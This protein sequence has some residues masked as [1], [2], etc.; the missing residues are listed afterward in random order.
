MR[1]NANDISIRQPLAAL[2]RA[3]FMTLNARADVAE[4]PSAFPEPFL[5]Y[6][7]RSSRE[8]SLPDLDKEVKILIQTLSSILVLLLTREYLS[9]LLHTSASVVTAMC[10]AACLYVELLLFNNSRHR[11]MRHPTRHMELADARSARCRRKTF[12]LYRITFRQN[13]WFP[14]DRVVTDECIWLNRTIRK[15]GCATSQ[16]KCTL[17]ISKTCHPKVLK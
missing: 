11:F 2:I 7:V 3:S 9:L 10:P 6:P 12:V 8:P 15:Q 14:T 1:S 5:R 17:F 4:T 16:V 13:H